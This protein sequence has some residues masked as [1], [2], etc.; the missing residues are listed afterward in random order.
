M[1]LQD[2]PLIQQFK[3]DV[4]QR[5]ADLVDAI[6][7]GSMTQD[8]YKKNCGEVA[9]LKLSLLMLDETIKAYTTGDDEDSVDN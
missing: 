2:D 8:A 5:I 6:A 3:F 7:K 1:S 4:N 9:G